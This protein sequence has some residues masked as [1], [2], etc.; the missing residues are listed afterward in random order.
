MAVGHGP[1]RDSAAWIVL[2]L[3]SGESFDIAL[4]GAELAIDGDTLAWSPDSGQLAFSMRD[5]AAQAEAPTV[6]DV[7]TREVRDLTSGQGEA[8]EWRQVRGLAWSPDG[9]EIAL[10]ATPGDRTDTLY[11]VGVE[12]GEARRIAEGEA[13]D[14]SPDGAQLAYSAAVSGGTERDIFVVNAD[15]TQPHP[16]SD[17]PGSDSGATWSPDGRYVAFVESVYDQWGGTQEQ[18]LYIADAQGERVD[19]ITDQYSLGVFRWW[20]PGEL[21]LPGEPVLLVG[22]QSGNVCWVEVGQEI[23]CPFAGSFPAPDQERQRVLYADSSLR[24]GMRL[25]IGTRDTPGVC[26]PTPEGTLYPVG[27]VP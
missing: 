16:L 9:A 10:V 25:C 18:R 14:W 2:S 24:S 20:L 27:W 11:V 6:L 5:T 23:D 21:T 3:R 26:P 1:G 4:D 17:K 8:A 19:L 7:A 22:S 15:G 12:G 13:P